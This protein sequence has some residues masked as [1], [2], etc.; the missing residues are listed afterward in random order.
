MYIIND[1]IAHNVK[2]FRYLYIFETWAVRSF[3]SIARSVNQFSSVHYTH[4][5]QRAP[6]ELS[7]RKRC[8]VWRRPDAKSRSGETAGAAVPSMSVLENELRA[9]LYSRYLMRAIRM[10]LVPQSQ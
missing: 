9:R 5:S 6:R 8:F 10:R 1:L 7:M 3:G 4:R 2:M